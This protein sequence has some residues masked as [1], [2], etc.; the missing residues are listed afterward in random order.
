M[1][2]KRKLMMDVFRKDGV[3][4]TE[5]VLPSATKESALANPVAQWSF[6]VPDSESSINET[7]VP[8]IA[9]LPK[10]QLNGQ[11]GVF[12][13]M[14]EVEH[15]EEAYQAWMKDR[16]NPNKVILSANNWK[17]PDKPATY[18]VDFQ[19]MQQ[20]NMKT[21]Y[22]RSVKR[23]LVQ[24]RP[25]QWSFWVPTW[26]SAFSNGRLSGIEMMEVEVLNNDK[27]VFYPMEDFQMLEKAYLAWQQDHTQ[28]SKVVIAAKNW[29][30]TQKPALYEV[31][32]ETM[33]QTNLTTKF[34][35]SVKRV[36]M[37]NGAASGPVSVPSA[38]TV[39]VVAG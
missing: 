19:S 9:A 35:R 15:L 16:S 17:Y 25:V 8:G 14:T 38:I 7:R 6:W 11:R 33:Q 32:F 1:C 10:E 3:L 34:T 5:S 23:C 28:S 12:C 39:N 21:G 30:Y 24:R 27:G 26:D 4:P 13:P 20:E 31:C 2:R 37:S 18:V 29:K 22:K 36:S